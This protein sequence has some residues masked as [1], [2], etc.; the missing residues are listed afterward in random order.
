MRQAVGSREYMPLLDSFVNHIQAAFGKNVVSLVLYGSV[1]RGD[2][3]PESDVDLLLILEEVPP[4]YWERLQPLIPILRQLQR[5]P[6]WRALEEQG[7]F[8]SFSV[9]ILSREEADQNLP[10]YLD[11]IE[12]AQVFVD[13][14]GFFQGR[15]NALKRR[16]RELGARK[17]QRDGGWYWDLKPDLRP[18]EV[19]IL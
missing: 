11:M 15:L 10:L 2:A 18:G 12:E 9:L 16:L 17:I 7:A 6:C 19:I 13:R 14:A 1:A 5:E 4:I 8:P 3:R